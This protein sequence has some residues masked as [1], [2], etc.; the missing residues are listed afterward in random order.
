M[1]WGTATPSFYVGI[2]PRPATPDFLPQYPRIVVEVI[3]TQ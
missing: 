3:A 1:I 2:I